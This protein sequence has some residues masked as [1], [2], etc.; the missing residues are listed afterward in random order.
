M[1]TSFGPNFMAMAIEFNDQISQTLNPNLMF[2]FFKDY[3]NALSTH[4]AKMI[5]FG[6]KRFFFTMV[7]FCLFFNAILNGLK[8]V[9]SKGWSI[10]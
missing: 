2:S 3:C 4:F 5:M 9:T 10:C 6:Y 1:K 8:H 7:A